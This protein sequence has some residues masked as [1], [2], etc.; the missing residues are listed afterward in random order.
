ML[1]P[2]EELRKGKAK[3]KR[4]IEADY[5]SL[6]PQLVIFKAIWS[7]HFKLAAICLMALL[8]NAL[9]IAFAGML[10]ERSV[11]VPRNITTYPPFQSKFVTI[12]GTVGPH[13]EGS[14]QRMEPSGAYTGGTGNDQFLVAESNYSAGTSLPPWTDS[15][16]LYVPFVDTATMNAAQS[17]TARTMAFGAALNCTQ[18][19]AENYIAG[20]SIN[21]SGEHMAN[22]TMMMKDDDGKTVHC[23]RNGQRITTILDSGTELANKPKC[24]PGD[25]AI[26]FVLLMGASENASKAEHKFCSQI[27]M[28]GWARKPGGNCTYQAANKPTTFNDSNAIFLGCRPRLLAGSADVQI[29]NDGHV[30]HVTRLETIRELS[31][32]FLDEHFSNDASNLLDQANNYLIPPWPGLHGR[33][34]AANGTTI[35]TPPTS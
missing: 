26:E 35:L 8:S 20:T 19:E 21:K 30:Q 13:T 10:E 33:P 34:W 18:I 23:L 14:I 3:A 7:S 9:A 22:F 12:N 25:N 24:Q 15:K 31:R 4:S 28:F 6:P 2:L 27:T 1:Q 29:D 17:L 32:D 5:S 16:N 11:L